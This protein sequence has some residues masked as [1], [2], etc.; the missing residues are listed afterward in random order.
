[1]EH[2]EI[3]NKTF[4]AIR[5]GLL[6]LCVISYI[7]MLISSLGSHKVNIYIAIFGLVLF[8]VYLAAT[9]FGYDRF[10]LSPD[11]DSLTIKSI[12]SLKPVQIHDIRI[13]K[14]VLTRT[15]VMIARKEGKPFKISLD[16]IERAEKIR[17]YQFF[18]DYAKEHNLALE[19]HSSTML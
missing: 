8:S 5:I 2:L 13:L 14:I 6:S 19:K 11:A 12:N 9:W 18:V 7:A 1:M 4:R 16:F 10:W 15:S 3:S 17:I